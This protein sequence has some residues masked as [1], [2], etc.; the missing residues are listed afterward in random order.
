M[1]TPIRRTRHHATCF[2]SLG[3]TKANVAG[4]GLAESGI[5]LEILRPQQ[6]ALAKAVIGEQ[7]LITEAGYQE[8]AQRGGGS[9]I[10]L[11]LESQRFVRRRQ[12]VPVIDCLSNSRHNS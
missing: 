1:S 10:A 2:L 7:G 3:T 4:A 12:S 9:Q 5:V 11:A 8:K 6:G